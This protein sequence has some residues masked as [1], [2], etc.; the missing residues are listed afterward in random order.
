M[1]KL[2]LERLAALCGIGGPL[3]YWILVITLGL[4]EP[5][6]SPI[7]QSMSELGAATSKYQLIIN[8]LGFPL[9]GILIGV[10]G[11]GLNSNLN[12]NRGYWVGPLLIMLSGVSLFLVGVFHT[13][14]GPVDITSIGRIHRLVA[15][16]SAFSYILALIF[17][18]FRQRSDRRWRSLAGF[19]GT[20]ALVA[21][22]LSL[23]YSLE[24]TKP[25]LGLLQRLS[26]GIPLLWTVVTSI[27]L[28][29]LAKPSVADDVLA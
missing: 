20:L 27:Q 24:F 26:M 13:D 18:A 16:V 29:R 22:T 3:I 4:I 21:L 19:S 23:F 25:I 10:F 6:Y 1:H 12:R 9:L 28:W 8:T 11:Y 2:R 15:T 17:I 14:P 7:S 5:H